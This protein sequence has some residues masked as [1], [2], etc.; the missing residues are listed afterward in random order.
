MS[1][2]YGSFNFYIVAAKPD[3]QSNLSEGFVNVLVEL[4]RSKH[5]LNAIIPSL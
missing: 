2:Q 4:F 5:E 1:V 3:I